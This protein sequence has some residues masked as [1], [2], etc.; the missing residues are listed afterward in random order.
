MSTNKIGTNKIGTNKIGTNK[1]GTNKI[2]TNKIGTNKVISKEDIIYA[3]SIF[4]TAILAGI[5]NAMS[6]HHPNR[7]SLMQNGGIRPTVAPVI[8]ASSNQLKQSGETH[9][10]S[11]IEAQFGESKWLNTFFTLAGKIND[12]LYYVFENVAN[13]AVDSVIQNTVGDL[14][15]KPLNES[16]LDKL[17][18]STLIV[19]Q[20]AHDPAVQLALQNL[21]QELAGI[22]LQMLD[23]VTPQVNMILEKTLDTL[24]QTANKSAKGL[25]DSGMNF[26]TSLIGNIPIYGGIVSLVMAFLRGFN[27]AAYAGSPG[28]ELSIDSFITA[29][30]TVLKMIQDFNNEAQTLTANVSAVSKAVSGLSSSATSIPSSIKGATSLG[31]NV[32]VPTMPIP[33]LPNVSVP[34]MPNVSVPALSNVS[35]PALPALPVPALPVPALPVPALPG[36]QSRLE[37]STNKQ[38]GGAKLRKRI[39]HITRRLK[40]TINRFVNNKKFTRKS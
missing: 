2:G 26:V 29:F 39:N 3:F 36:T 38:M 31:T 24:N 11:Q 8:N 40:K 30:N 21:S 17:Q 25:V 28:V 9:L 12:T 35:V 10:K 22:S 13:K 20:M 37:G 5:T 15:T 34:T 6:M 16:L 23:T 18:N 27:D 7:I 32:P 19:T 4:T 1:I 33:A 14:G